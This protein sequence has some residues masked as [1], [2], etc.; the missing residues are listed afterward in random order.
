MKKIAIVSAME[1]ESAYTLEYLYK[2]DEWTRTFENTYQNQKLGIE[3][4]VRVLGVG[5]V[6]AAYQTAD[7]IHDIHPMLIIN[8][9]VAG[10]M[11]SGTDRGAVA[12][13]T[14]YVQ[15]DIRP[16]LEENLPYI[17]DTPDWIVEG[18]KEIAEEHGFSYECGRIATG[19]FF[20]HSDEKKKEIIHEF[21]PV[22]FDMESAAIAQVATAKEIAFESIRIF[23]DLADADAVKYA[24]RA[25]ITGQEELAIRKKLDRYPVIL[26][27]DFLT[28]YY[29]RI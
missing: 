1:R 23:S 4:V 20:L 3:V 8:V 11:I 16:Y 9:G 21:A 15:V 10:G 24:G 5:K 28:R 25:D 18:I 22:A 2:K 7:L 13:G 6:N 14:D 27:I 26:A 19:D 29:D 12:I 17:E